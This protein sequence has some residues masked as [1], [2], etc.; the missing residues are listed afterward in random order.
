[1]LK[2]NLETP[3]LIYCAFL[4]FVDEINKEIRV[5]L[6]SQSFSLIFH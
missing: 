5:A 6:N 1:M 3:F 4:A 2:E